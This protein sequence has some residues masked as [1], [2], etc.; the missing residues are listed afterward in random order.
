MLVK[1]KA[2]DWKAVYGSDGSSPYHVIDGVRVFDLKPMPHHLLVRWLGKAQT[3]AGV[4]LPQN[5]QRAGLM[6]GVLLRVGPE[7]DWRLQ[8][9]Q[10]IEFDGLSEKEFLGGQSPDGRDPVFFMREEDVMGIVRPASPPRLEMLNTRLLIKPDLEVSE[11]NGIVIVRREQKGLILSGVVV[12]RDVESVEDVVPGDRV[13]YDRA[14]ATELK[15]GD[16][17][18]E[19][20]HVVPFKAV[21]AV[22]EREVASGTH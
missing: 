19:L 9:G 5:R 15:L 20:H 16:F 21:E 8:E 18:G 22:E 3:K 17:E 2:E 1:A 10:T 7:C 13:F 12:A 14:M 6:K 4:I 11:K